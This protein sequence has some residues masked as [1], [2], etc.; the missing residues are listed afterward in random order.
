MQMRREQVWQRPGTAA[1]L[2]EY[3]PKLTA[4]D[5]KSIIE[6]SAQ[7]P[8]DSVRKPG[9]DDMVKLNEISKTG[10]IINAFEAAKLADSMYGT[11]STPE[12]KTKKKKRTPKSRLENKQN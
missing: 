1:F 6:K 7:V 9:S 10:G 5:V 2:L 12:K 3:F 11:M 8:A 4:Q